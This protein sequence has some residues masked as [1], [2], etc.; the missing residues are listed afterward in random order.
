MNPNPAASSEMWDGPEFSVLVTCHY[1]VKSIDEFFMRIK[2]AWDATGRT[3]E[4]V[5]VNDGSTDGTWEK[6]TALYAQHPEVSAVVDFFRN[7]GQMAAATACIC[8]SSGKHFFI[9]DS[10]LQLMPEELPTLLAAFDTGQDLVTGYR[11]ERHDSLFRIV[12]SKIANMIMRKA[13]NSTLRDFGCTFKFY[14]GNLIRAFNL[15]PH[16]IFSNVDLIASA[17]RCVEVPVTHRARQHGKSGWTFAKLWKYNMENLVKL[18]QRP[19]QFIAAGC[20]ILGL[21]FFLRILA[22]FFSSFSVLDEATNGLILNTLVFALI[23]LLAV[24]SM[25]GEFTIR[26]FVML[27]G[28]PGYAVREVLRRP[29]HRR[30]ANTPRADA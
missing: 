23:T 30:M 19:F 22:G 8:E 4:I 5:M 13:S 1:E 20:T 29:P 3:Y 24:L 10:D 12:P 11:A 17:G 21:V 2:S 15:G 14:H 27:R 28:Q 18:S 6:L 16:R 26:G 25:I 7:A 9:M